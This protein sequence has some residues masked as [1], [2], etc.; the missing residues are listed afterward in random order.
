MDKQK[1]N[2]SN[3]AERVSFIR[4]AMQADKWGI[5]QGQLVS[6]MLDVFEESTKPGGIGLWLQRIYELPSGDIQLEGCYSRLIED[7]WDDKNESERVY[8]T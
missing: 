7:V 5:T 2:W 4:L 6:F 8:E 3:K 1:K